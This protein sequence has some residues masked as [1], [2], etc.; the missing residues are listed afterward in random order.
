MRDEDK[1][2][3]LVVDDDAVNRKMLSMI[4][5]QVEG[6][7]VLPAASG[8]EAVQAAARERPAMVLLDVMMPDMDGFD[9]ALELQ[10]VTNNPNLPVLFITAHGRN[11]D[12]MRKGYALGA[13]DYLAKPVERSVIQGKVRLFADLHL[14]Q[15]RL[16][17]SLAEVERRSREQQALLAAAR[18]VLSTEEFPV[19]ARAIFDAC[20]EVL[21]AQAGYVALLSADGSE[22]ELLF[23]EAGG[24][25]CTVDPNLPMPIRGL[26]SEV[27]RTGRAAYEN[28]FAAGPWQAFL[29]EGHAR[30]DN[31]LFAPLC[32]DGKVQGLL[33]L[34]NRP[35]GFDEAAARLADIFGEYA[36]VALANARRIERLKGYGEA[37]KRAQAIAK[38]GSFE[39]DCAT[40]SATC[41]D[42]LYAIFGL[43]PAA[44]EAG[45]ERF[46]A[47][48]HPDDLAGLGDRLG[49]LLRGENFAAADFRILGARGRVL[50]LH[51]QAVVERNAEGEPAMVR[52]ICLDYT[53][54]RQF[55]EEFTRSQKFKAVGRLAGGI[56]HEI[57][58]PAQY[59]LANIDFVERSLAM[60]RGAPGGAEGPGNTDSA[61]ADGDLLEEMRSAL[62]D[63]RHGLE[64]I[65]AIVRAVRHFA[66]F[67]SGGRAPCDVNR[68]AREAAS[69]ARG[70][71]ERHA[72]LELE[73]AAD[74]RPV[75]CVPGELGQVILNLLL[76]A[77]AAVGERYAREGRGRIILGTEAGDGAVLVRVRDDGTGIAPEDMER[78]F[79]P[80]FST[81]EV[82]RGAGVGLSIAHSIVTR[83][84]GTIEVASQLGEG[85]EFV[86]RLPDGS[87]GADG[88]G[89]VRTP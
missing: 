73:L 76:N 38:V 43:A 12:Y 49:H 89:S 34:A 48:V 5:A 84:G 27:Y 3:V 22:N 7:R 52:G 81:R 54:R 26:R 82:G 16:R 47:R 85:T 39:Y 2:V 23:L 30:L 67:E 69:L 17:R 9:T 66:D 19:V 78:I 25:P 75:S 29:P 74:L 63:S 6:T 77:S 58:T 62:R 24:I 53:E 42:E 88:D 20:R 21:G 72:E 50:H 28:D 10:R 79:D 1:A 64:S 36:G 65:A 11:A 83:L 46:A 57:N 4:V 59:V 71:V 32:V 41:S 33:G 61:A 51:G 56:A 80:F 68:S 15:Q 60:L 45:P 70:E 87:P 86:V 8:R 31:V 18:S 35:D 37:L 14:Q 44:L 55:E 40:A 13:V